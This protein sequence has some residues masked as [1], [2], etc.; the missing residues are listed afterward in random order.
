MDGIG[1]SVKRYVW[2]RVRSSQFQ[3]MNSASFASAAASMSGVSVTHVSQ[4]ELQG[5]ATTLN[6]ATV[7]LSAKDH[8]GIRKVHAFQYV[9]EQI[10]TSD[11][12]KTL[13]TTVIEPV[14]AVEHS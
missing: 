13:N 6:Q 8:P 14:N 12:T 9:Q 3:V 4:E 7:F 5:R 10:H 2:L 11:L 1:G